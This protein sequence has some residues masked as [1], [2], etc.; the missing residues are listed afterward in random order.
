MGSTRVLHRRYLRGELDEE[1]W[2]QHLTQPFHSAGPINLRPFLDQEWYE[3]GGYE[4]AMLGISFHVITIPSMP[5]VPGGWLSKHGSKL[6]DGTPPFS[7]LFSRDRFVRRVQAVKKQFK[8]TLTHPLLF[9]IATAPS[10]ERALG[11]KAAFVEWERLQTGVGPEETKKQVPCSPVQN[12]VFH[13]GGSS[14][15]NVSWIFC[16]YALPFLMTS[17]VDPLRPTE[18]PLGIDNPLSSRKYCA[19]SEDAPTRIPATPTIK[20]IKSWK[21]LSVRAGE[22]YLG[23]ETKD[24]EL[25]IFVSWDGSVFEDELVKEWLEEI[26]K[27][28][29]Y[30]L[31]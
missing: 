7:V 4:V 16:D 27:A 6:E 22:L 3:S 31:C 17:Q 9:E 2:R 24:Q 19:R 28:T 23:A 26:R 11:S 1:E 10:L 8:H 15:G 18:Y 12:Y 5:T 30:Y 21:K 20:I 25:S 14:L 13:N 29:E